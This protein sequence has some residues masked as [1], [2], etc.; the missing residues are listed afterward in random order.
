MSMGGWGVFRV[1]SRN[2][3]RLEKES[4]M[5]DKARTIDGE[6]QTTVGRETASIAGSP[7]RFELGRN[8]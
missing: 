6:T 1:G 4:G 8:E 7:E 3:L 5:G 2:R